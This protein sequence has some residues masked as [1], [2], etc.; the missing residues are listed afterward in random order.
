MVGGSWEA[1]KSDDQQIQFSKAKTILPHQKLF[2]EFRAVP[3]AAFL[4]SRSLVWL[5]GFLPSPPRS[6]LRVQQHDGAYCFVQCQWKRGREWWALDTHGPIRSTP[7]TETRTA[8]PEMNRRNPSSGARESTPPGI[9]QGVK[10]H[11]PAHMLA[12]SGS[13]TKVKVKRTRVSLK[14]HT[15]WTWWEVR[16]GSPPARSLS[17]NLKM[18]I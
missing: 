16:H 10:G 13:S 17:V 11:P 8:S 4:T 6:A 15:N 3:P 1:E 7:R 9:A 12:A 18:F 14:W 5:P 2:H